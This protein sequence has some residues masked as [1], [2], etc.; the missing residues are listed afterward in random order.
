VGIEGWYNDE[1]DPALARWHDGERW[2]AHTLVKDQWQGPGEPPPPPTEDP[3]AA[4]FGVIEPEPPIQ[5]LDAVEDDEEFV[6]WGSTP[7]GAHFASD[8][9][10]FE[11]A[12]EGYATEGHYPA[13]ARGGIDWQ[14]FAAPLAGVAALVVALIAFQVVQGDGDADTPVQRTAAVGDIDDALANARQGLAVDVADSDLKALIR[15][16]CDVGAGGSIQEVASDAAITVSDPAALSP[17]LAAA[18]RGAA[19]YCPN[20][21][22]QATGAVDDIV[23]AAS[24]Q[25]P[26]TTTPTITPDTT[27]SS[28]SATSSATRS[29]SSSKGTASTKSGSSSA[30][31]SNSVNR[32]ETRSQSSTNP[33]GLS[34]STDSADKTAVGNVGNQ[35]QTT[36]TTVIPPPTTEA[37]TATE[38][39]P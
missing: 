25:V 19:D 16:L 29:S 5:A 13:H 17:V 3:W 33:G 26:T 38:P 39:A 28:A 27:Q 23:A 30:S 6:M 4:E 24:L 11:M 32:T 7:A 8:P 12:D 20:D 34:S 2:T 1:V 15:G 37:T 36:N 18:A 9:D 14:R 22:A 35:Q 10:V 21:T 31:G